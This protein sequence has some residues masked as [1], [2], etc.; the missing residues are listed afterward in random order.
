M[1]VIEVFPTSLRLAQTL[2]GL[3]RAVAARFRS[4]V[5]TVA[6]IMVVCRRIKR[7]EVKIQGLLAQYRA[8]GLQTRVGRSSVARSDAG[9]PQR[10][11]AANRLPLR[12]AWLLP[13]VPSEAACFA[14][15]FR[16]I[17]AEP[18][19]VGLLAASAQARRILRP[20]CRMLGIEAV[21]LAPETLAPE[22]DVATP[23]SGRDAISTPDRPKL[24]PP[25]P[26]P[27]PA[28]PLRPT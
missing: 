13:L 3:C 5:M 22:P 7:A 15:Q 18:E 28:I 19:M 4:G 24:P 16:V 26:L 10:L 11:G 17:L 8:G 23:Q 6:M 25:G 14:G 9:G 21:M 20:V 12:F 1:N 27:P 2:D